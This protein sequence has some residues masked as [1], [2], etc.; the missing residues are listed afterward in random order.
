MAYMYPSPK[1]EEYPD[2]VLREKMKKWGIL[3]DKG[4]ILLPVLLL[5]ARELA[6]ARKKPTDFMSVMRAQIT[7]L[8]TRV[9]ELE[10]RAGKKRERTK[11]DLVYEFCKEELEEKHF[12]K[13]VAI[14]T[15]LG[16]IVGVGDTILEAYNKAKERTGK[17]QFD[18]KRVGYKYIHKV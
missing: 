8:Q 18:F 6:H 13:I 5:A 12:G 9:R 10:K 3:K 15:E 17:E 2:H 11:A 7:D 1:E 14:D 16:Q 4:D